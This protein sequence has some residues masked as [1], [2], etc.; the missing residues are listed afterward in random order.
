MTPPA[1]PSYEERGNTAYMG[2]D[3][4]ES[5]TT[6]LSALPHGV[7]AR[8]KPGQG[9]EG[10]VLV[11][12][13]TGD[14]I[15]MRGSYFLVGADTAHMDYAINNP[16]VSR[17]HATITYENGSYYIMDNKSTNGT[18]IEG[19]RVP[20]YEKVELTDGAILTLG[21]EVFQTEVGRG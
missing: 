6:V 10:L 9:G 5:E 12:T 13:S 3:Y 2:I 15:K 16:S 20:P 14:R 18:R 11:R 8:P 21:N 7:P 1:P 4:D 19:V 17:H